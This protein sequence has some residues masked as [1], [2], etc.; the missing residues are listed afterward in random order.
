MFN[1]VRLIGKEDWWSFDDEF[2]NYE[3]WENT[4]YMEENSRWIGIKRK[5]KLWK[6]DLGKGK[7]RNQ[8]ST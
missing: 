3:K 6:E 4:V 8:I 2:V 1:V 7:K 5:R